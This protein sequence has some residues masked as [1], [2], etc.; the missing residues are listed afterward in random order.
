MRGNIDLGY[1]HT[2]VE[3]RMKQGQLGKGR[4]VSDPY[5]P[6][7]I[8]ITE[9]IILLMPTDLRET[10]L[11][12]YTT[13]GSSD[14]QARRLGKILKKRIS[15]QNYYNMLHILHHRYEAYSEIIEKNA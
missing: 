8:K 2:T 3:Y 11:I 6:H 12:R 4:P 5:I 14:N 9:Q 1:P 7:G 10:A 15:R 13:G